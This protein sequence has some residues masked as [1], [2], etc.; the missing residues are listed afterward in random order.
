[1]DV[2]ENGGLGGVQEKPGDGRAGESVNSQG[3]Q[4]VE[5]RNHGDGADAAAYAAES[6]GAQVLPAV[7]CHG[8]ARSLKGGRDDIVYSG[9]GGHCRHSGSAQGVH[10]ALQ[11]DGAHGGDGKLQAHGYADGGDIAHTAEIGLQ[12][13]FADMQHRHLQLDVHQAGQ[14]GGGLRDNGGVGRALHVHAEAGH[15]QNIQQHIDEHRHDKK[16]QGR[17]AVAQGAEHAGGQIVENGGA[18][19]HEHD[20]DV[21]VGLVVNICRGVGNAEQGA[22]GEIG[23]QG[24]EQGEEKTQPDQ[25]AGTAADSLGVSGTKALGD[26]DGKAGADAQGKAQHQKVQRPR[27]AHGGKGVDT[28]QT[29]DDDAVGQIIK[30]LKQVSD[31]KRSAEGQN[32]AERRTCGHVSCH[33]RSSFGICLKTV[34]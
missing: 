1:M 22:C 33:D 30:L 2:G 7:G 8:D 19:A 13:R 14:T 16:Q 21:A 27:G 10:R 3:Q 9:A 20:E 26:G 34:F 24:D 11:N 18:G 5:H 31:Q 4:A 29:A 28:Q 32:T 15:E 12:V 25:L 23:E 17:A 6:G